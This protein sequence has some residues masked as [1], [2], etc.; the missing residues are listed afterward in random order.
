MSAHP[1]RY[2]YIPTSHRQAM[3]RITAATAE[4]FKLQPRELR[5]KSNLIALVRPRQIAMYVIR[6]KVSWVSLP[7][8]G[9]HFGGKHHTTVEHSINT[10][11]NLR[12]H[13]PE[14]DAAV[15]IIEETI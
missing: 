2:P 14:V 12:E 11:A 4:L 13:D 3:A 1:Q 8:I 9:R 5:R 10:I 6:R 7:S 15:R